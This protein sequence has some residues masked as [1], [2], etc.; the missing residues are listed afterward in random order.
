MHSS[1]TSLLLFLSDSVNPANCSNLC[2]LDDAICTRAGVRLWDLI[3]TLIS[4]P[5]LLDKGCLFCSICEQ[6]SFTKMK[7]TE[8]QNFNFTVWPLVQL[9]EI[10]RLKQNKLSSVCSFISRP[11]KTR[12]CHCSCQHVSSQGHSVTE[13]KKEW[14]DM[15]LK[16]ATKTPCDVM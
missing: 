15:K 11:E 12:K 4:N 6:V 1:L 5:K 3:I 14:F 7:K 2:Q 8:E 10:I 13:I 9:L 16:T